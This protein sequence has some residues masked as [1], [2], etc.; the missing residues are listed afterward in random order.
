MFAIVM[1]SKTTKYLWLE[2]EVGMITLVMQYKV[3]AQ[4]QACFK[5]DK[6]IGCWNLIRDL[7]CGQIQ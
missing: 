7:Q 3:N 5:T 2:F 1:Q 6:Y 4:K